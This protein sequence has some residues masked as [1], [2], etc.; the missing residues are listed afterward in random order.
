MLSDCVSVMKDLNK[1]KGGLLDVEYKHHVFFFMVRF[2]TGLWH[3]NCPST[4]CTSTLDNNAWKT[5]RTN[6]FRLCIFVNSDECLKVVVHVIFYILIFDRCTSILNYPSSQRILI[7]M[8]AWDVIS[9]LRILIAPLHPTLHQSASSHH[10]H[11][12][13]MHP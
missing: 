8:Y 6:A 12:D 3:V 10:A 1:S 7:P 4:V 2:T 9:C 11:H 13:E 5:K